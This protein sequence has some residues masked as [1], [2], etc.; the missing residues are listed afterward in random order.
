MKSA[1]TWSVLLVLCSVH[2]AWAAK[3][4]EHGV[5]ALDI[6]VEQARITLQLETPL[7]GLLGF[8]R[9][10]RTDAERKAADAAVAKLRA[11]ASL[12]RIDPAA[13]CTLAGV[14]LDSAA[15]KLGLAATA[16]GAAKDGHAD[17]DATVSFSCQAGHKAAYIDVELFSAF[18]RMARLEVQ[19]AGASG[20]QKATLRRPAKRV[21]LQ[22]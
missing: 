10:P 6:A 15:L 4:H 20:Q 9:A 16:P 22:R 19:V 18:P 2:P 8:E 11:A 21:Q 1:R 13:G 5:A 7:D 14:E 3:A 17:L 12:F